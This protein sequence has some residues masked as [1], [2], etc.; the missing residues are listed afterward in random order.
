MC[1]D[2]KVVSFYHENPRHSRSPFGSIFDQ[3]IAF[4]KSGNLLRMRKV[5]SIYLAD[6]SRMATLGLWV[7]PTVCIKQ[8]YP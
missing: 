8:A 1:S 3:V 6:V 2:K 5:V 7:L 4:L